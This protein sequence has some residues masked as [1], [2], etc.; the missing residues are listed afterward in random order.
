MP[1]ASLPR[2]R[3]RQNGPLDPEAN[4]ENAN[5]SSAKDSMGLKRA[6]RTRRGAIV[7][8]SFFYLVAIVFLILVE[9][10]N[11]RGT[12][13][14]GSMYF[15][16]LDLA[17]IFPQSAP[18]TLTL[19]D[20]IA[21]SLG[22]HDFYQVG[23][24]NYCEGYQTNG[25]THCSKPNA[26]FWFNPVEILLNELLAGASIA[27]PSEV[28][29]ILNIL[30]IASHIMFGFFLS[31]LVL[32]AVLIILSPIV[33][34]SRWWS[35]PIGIL[36]FIAAL[37]VV[38]AAIL[39][40]VISYVAQ[41]ALSSQPDLGVTASVGTKMLAFEWTAAGFTLLAFIVHAGLGC[42]CTSRRD[43][44]TGRKGGRHVHQTSATAGNGPKGPKAPGF[45]KRS[46]SSGETA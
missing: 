30:R 15:F 35:L 34:Y 1:S 16:K 27:L 20:S 44:R 24:W 25:I 41:Y 4:K 32:D 19:Q 39:A 40:T 17:D 31:G 23:L 7:V 42:C 22:L 28:N 26:A 6:T 45:G 37:L 36:S 10:G 5:S 14:L 2:F 13:I 12:T 38:V 33:L 8:L 9:I 43:I 46:H 29:S 18:T 3:K 11:T 21:R